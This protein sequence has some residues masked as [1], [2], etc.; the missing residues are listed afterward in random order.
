MEIVLVLLVLVAL[1]AVGA[2]LGRRIRATQGTV[3]TPIPP[4]TTGVV[5]AALAPVGSVLLAGERWTARTTDDRPLE[6]DTRVRLVRL[7][8][9]TAIVEPLPGPTGSTTEPSTPPDPPADRT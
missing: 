4:G 7:D 2:W 3:G 6:R 9:L 8:G 1:A 5:Q